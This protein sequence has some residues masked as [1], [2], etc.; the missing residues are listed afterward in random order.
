[1]V[2]NPV[3]LA[4]YMLWNVIS[5]SCQKVTQQQHQKSGQQNMAHNPT[6][7]NLAPTLAGKI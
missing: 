6:P 2:H 3:K 1:M 5:E 4:E 7:H